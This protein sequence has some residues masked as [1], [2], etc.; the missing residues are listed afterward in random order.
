MIK[1]LINKCVTC[2]NTSKLPTKFDPPVG[3]PRF[4]NLL[5]SSSPIFTGI[6]FDILGPLKFLLKHGARG[7]KSVSKGYV[8]V[9]I[10]VIT[11]Y[12]TFYLME[13]ATKIYIETA[14]Q[15]DV[16]IEVL[17]ASHQFLNVVERC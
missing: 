2:I 8:L 11:K 5:E 3:P 4:L 16:S 6:S 12:V 13:D 1:P 14:L 7:A 15:K 9:A 10:C 17:A